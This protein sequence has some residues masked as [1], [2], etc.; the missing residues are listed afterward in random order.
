MWELPEVALP[1]SADEVLFSLRH[2]ITVT[3]F[4]VRVVAVNRSRGRWIR[5]SR[6]KTLP[7]TGLA[8]KILRRARIIQ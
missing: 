3:D 6:L 2:S 1:Q 8:K 4:A 7:L 5:I